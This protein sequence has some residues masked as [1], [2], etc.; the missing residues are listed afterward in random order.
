MLQ[1]DADSIKHTVDVV[2]IGGGVIGLTIAR[3]LAL[4]GAGDICLIER[5]S[6]GREASFA[7]AGMLA[8]QAEANAPDDFFSL[9]CRSRDLYANF[10]AS[11]RDE[12]GVDIELDRTGTLYL[13]LTYHDLVD[14]E[15][16]FHWQTAAGLPVEKLTAAQAR[17]L[18]PCI[19]NN[20]VGALRFPL[21][22]QLENRRLLSALTNSVSKLGVSIVTETSV[23]SVRVERDSVR[24]VQTSRGFINCAKVVVAAGTWSGFVQLS[25]K[26]VE[27]PALPALKV[28]PVRGQMI[29]FD[30]RPQ[31]TRHVIYSPRGYIVPRQ[32]GRLLAGSTSEYA[33]FAKQ[34]TAGGI[35]TILANAQEISPAISSLP[36]VDTWSGLRPRAPDNLPVLGPCD[37]IGG[38]F[39]ATGHYRNGI[40]L[41]PVTGELIAEAIVD[42][43]VSPLLNPFS[44]GRFHLVRV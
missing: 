2:V 37:E 43:V 14:I 23:E 11:L 30:A 20:I 18:E 8:P 7:A 1:N 10:A 34:V 41:A 29:S 12:T 21:D 19:S 26:T 24:G 40:L 28:E 32:D 44:P 36:I 3:A 22:V 17:E 15:K 39:Y 16:R 35:S 9:A 25:P 31:V 27:K 38:L 5:A 6:L 4:R 33:G 13:A 42:G